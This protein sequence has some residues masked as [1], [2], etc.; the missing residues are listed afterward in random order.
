MGNQE[1]KE[2]KEGMSYLSVSKVIFEE[3]RCEKNND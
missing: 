1:A 3:S 2:E